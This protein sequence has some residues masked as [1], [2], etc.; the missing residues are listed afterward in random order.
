MSNSKDQL[1]GFDRNEI[2][3]Q[4]SANQPWIAAAVISWRNIRIRLG[5]AMVTTSTMFLSVAFLMYV[6][7]ILVARQCPSAVA[8]LGKLQQDDLQRYQWLVVMAFII[9][10][11]G[12]ANAL[13]MAVTERF[14]EIGTIKC[15]G[16]LDGFVV[17][18]FLIES[19]LMGFVGSLF[20][21]FLGAFGA[22]LFTAGRSTSAIWK[23]VPWGLGDL[24]GVLTWGVLTCLIVSVLLGTLLSVL[25]AVFPALR[26]AKLPAAAALRTEI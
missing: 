20:G 24:S 17:K 25:A 12:I 10:G 15:V 14:R 9:C 6:F 4:I 8:K 16:A 21:S 5:R 7:T 18:L 3:K 13:L 26:A 11:V 22:L 23:E 2:R 19:M 1:F